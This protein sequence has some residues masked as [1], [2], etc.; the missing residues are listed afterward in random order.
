MLSPLYTGPVYDSTT[1]ATTTGDSTSEAEENQ[2]MFLKLL[3]A[4]LTNQNPLDPM[5]NTEFTAQLAQFSSLEQLTKIA[6]S[7][8]GIGRMESM[9]QETQV[10]GYIGKD[11]TYAGKVF[12]VTDGYA[13]D[14]G[15]ILDSGANVEAIVT[16]ELGQT[17][18]DV[19][20]GYLQAGSHDF[21]WDATDLVGQQVPDGLYQ[22]DFVATDTQGNSVAVNTQWVSA[23]VTGFSKDSDGTFY[24]LLGD[25][26]VP[27]ADV[28]S[29]SLAS[30]DS[31]ESDQEE[32]ESEGEET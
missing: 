26:A 5:D 6:G 10:M 14:C 19:D 3:M 20:L 15:F 9:L 8:E 2:E 31:T 22:V 32:S 28:L 18:A 11:V 21:D 25:V 30:T 12:P 7:L 27:L 16:N 1:T 13:G 29:V 4:Q 23:T 17:V 24:L